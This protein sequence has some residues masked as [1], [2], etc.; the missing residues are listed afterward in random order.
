MCTA[1]FYGLDASYTTSE[2]AGKCTSTPGSVC[3]AGSVSMSGTA[4]GPGTYCTGED[5]SLRPAPCPPG[6]YGTLPYQSTTG[7]TSPACTD[8]CAAGYWCPVGSVNSTSAAC[9]AGR[10]ASTAGSNS[11]ACQGPCAPGYFCPPAS[12]SATAQPCPAGRWGGLGETSST[13]SGLC[14]AGTYCPPASAVPQLCANGTF[15]ANRGAAS[16]T[17]CPLS[18]YG[19]GAGATNV[20]LCALCAAGTQGLRPGAV[21]SD[22]CTLCPIGNASA[23]AGSTCTACTPGSYSAAPGAVHCTPCPVGTSNAHP[24]GI[25]IL[26]CSLCAPGSFSA[27]RGAAACT[28]CAPGSYQDAPG[29][30]AG[31]Q[32]CPNG[33]FNEGT[34][35][36]TRGAC[37]PCFN[38]RFGPRGASLLT[39]CSTCPITTFG[40]TCVDL[41]VACVDPFVLKI[42]VRRLIGASPGH[43]AAVVGTGEFLDVSVIRTAGSVHAVESPLRLPQA[44]SDF[45]AFSAYNGVLVAVNAFGA[46]FWAPL[47]EPLIAPWTATAPDQPAVQFTGCAISGVAV[48]NGGRIVAACSSG[49]SSGAV[50][51]VV[52]VSTSV[53]TLSNIP[54]SSVQTLGDFDGDG[55]DD[56]LCGTRAVVFIAA[57]G[58]ARGGPTLQLLFTDADLRGVVPIGDLDGDGIPDVAIVTGAQVQELWVFRLLRDGSVRASVLLQSFVGGAVTNV[59]SPGDVTNDGVADLVV[60][61]ASSLVVLP[62][63]CPQCARAVAS[64]TGDQRGIGVNDS[65]MLQF[66]CDVQDIPFATL[67]NNSGV[68]AIVAFSAPLGASYTGRW[69]TASSLRVTITNAAGAVSADTR[70]GLL[71]ATARVCTGAQYAVAGSWGA[72]QGPKILSAAAQDTGHHAG[73]GTNDS[74]LVTFDSDVDARATLALNVSLGTLKGHWVNPRQWRFIVQDATGADAASATRVGH[75]RIGGSAQ[76]ADLSSPTVPVHA[77]LSGSWG[78]MP[79]P[80]IVSATAADTGRAE[81]LNQGDTVLIVF[82]ED[83]ST[84]PPAG[85]IS[86][87][88]AAVPAFSASWLTPRTLQLNITADPTVHPLA[89]SAAA[90][91]SPGTLTVTVHAGGSVRSMDLSSPAS[92][93]SAVVQGGWGN[94][95]VSVTSSNPKALSTAGGDLVTLTLAATI[96]AA[97]THASANY[98]NGNRTYVSPTCSVVTGGGAVQCSSAPGVGTGYAWTLTLNGVQLATSSGPL[99]TTSYGPPV[100]TNVLIGGNES[101]TDAS[102]AGGQTV[103]IQGRNFGS[104]ATNAVSRVRFSPRGYAVVFEPTNCSVTTVPGAAAETITCIMP[105]C[106]GTSYVFSLAIDGQET[107]DVSLLAAAPA[108]TNVTAAA[109]LDTGGGTLV[110]ISGDHF[111]VP[112]NITGSVTL[113]YGALLLGTSF[114]A[115][116][117]SVSVAQYEITCT[118]TPGYGAN[119]WWRVTV[120][121]V[122]SA[123]FTS[124][125]HYVPPSLAPVSP[126]LSIPTAGA[127]ITLRGGGF[128]PAFP[129]TM[130]ARVDSATAVT[131]VQAHGT[132]NVTLSVPP[133]I[134]AVHTLAIGVAGT[135]SP[136]LPFSYRAPMVTGAA[137]FAGGQD[138]WDVQLVGTNFGSTAAAVN[139][140]IAGVPC[141]VL[142]AG[143]TGVV[144]RTHVMAGG[145]ATFAVAGQGATGAAVKFDPSVSLPPSSVTDVVRAPGGGANIGAV[146]GLPLTGGGAVTLS[147]SNLVPNSPA[148]GV[149]MRTGPAW[150]GPQDCDIALAALNAS[151]ASLASTFCVPGSVA[152]APGAVSC[153]LPASPTALVYLSVVTVVG[154]ACKSYTTPK[155]VLY[156]PPRV[157]GTAGGNSMLTSGGTRIVLTGVNFPTD[158]GVF[159]GGVACAAVTVHNN[160][161][162]LT[163]TA[164]AGAG[165]NVTL[166]LNS[167]AYPGLGVQQQFH[168]A[169]QPPLVTGLDTR[170]GP[171]IGG[172]ALEIRGSGFAAGRTS[173]AI[174]PYP[175]AAVL[176]VSADG[177]S[178]W[179]IAAAGHGSGLNVS[180]SVGGQN[181]SLPR[182]FSFWP[183]VVISTLPPIVD[184]AY[185]G[186]LMLNG[187]NFVPLSIAVS[188]VRVYINEVPCLSV[189]RLSDTSLSCTASPMLV[190]HRAT[191]RVAVDGATGEGATR[192]ACMMNF[193]GPANGATCARCPVGALCPGLDV[194]PLPLPGYSRVSEAVFSA[195]VPPQSCT[196]LDDATVRSRLEGGSSV[197]DAYA[198]CATG[199]SDNAGG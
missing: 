57:N 151:G 97:G 118:T 54:C 128:T 184:G 143:D 152:W 180:V 123:T 171:P 134:G 116:S 12:V 43:I 95:V 90:A 72:Q 139:A 19:V 149:L 140:T 4:C 16:C 192:V 27:S 78:D 125:L 167:S 129:T 146:N 89:G 82:D 11:S 87:S 21:G 199:Y 5:M 92:T 36:A 65:V 86:F 138:F 3:P 174:G 60:T 1:G 150:A 186:A 15:N 195:C 120:L 75:V 42:P 110:V 189:A 34:G 30:T 154:D 197:A 177:N 131:T 105:P 71:T 67:G 94:H 100:I 48:L 96:N 101:A 182:A 107:T 169:Y 91:T 74:V 141:A 63:V 99:S 179:I 22:A 190:A 132:A 168:L 106:A 124:T 104:V 166:S 14:D 45:V 73:F 170:S 164:P 163:C 35:A 161:T 44:A 103:L 158:S 108:I 113:E 84:P 178:L 136:T 181:A 193:Y 58:D 64:D 187:S 188:S 23:V 165:A 142:S 162:S 85:V 51:A 47:G 80:Q 109:P 29:S 155:V 145:I 20:T 32:L 185:G 156:D 183:P 98:S 68:D 121:G 88:S 31:C 153:T 148:K 198:N 144:C 33:T 160:C 38:N 83:T 9:P 69:E 102:E 70:I 137:P 117:C 46:A 93:A 52:L 127:S 17:P 40:P 66:P 59:T 147:G 39:N 194:E 18:T 81:G 159:V 61:N 111:G 10:Y 76:S 79:S 49:G 7:L 157:T 13:C 135:W 133:G 41:D 114:A 37:T 119:L 115:T 53:T 130:T 112:V 6:V 176:R 56:V 77:V 122:T 2:C 26:N 62:L 196:G 24:G 175:V 8:K 173:V 25:S 28:T 191:V 50:L 55:Y 126:P 172:T